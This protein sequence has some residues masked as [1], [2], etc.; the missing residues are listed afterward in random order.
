MKLKEPIADVNLIM[1]PLHLALCD[2]RLK[3]L[4]LEEAMLLQSEE[5]CRYEKARDPVSQWLVAI[6]WPV[7][8]FNISLIPTW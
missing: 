3:R 1:S 5:M 7:E 6:L 2:A 8:P 4:K